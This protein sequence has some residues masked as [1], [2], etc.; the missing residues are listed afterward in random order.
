MFG[1][2]PLQKERFLVIHRFPEKMVYGFDRYVDLA[3]G[4]PGSLG[5]SLILTA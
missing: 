1:T 2:V 5:Q 4:V 3:A